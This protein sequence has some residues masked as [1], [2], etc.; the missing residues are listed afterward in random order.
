MAEKGLLTH[1]QSLVSLVTITLFIPCLANFFMI[2]KE[3]GMKI[4]IFMAVIVFP[5]AF[6][7]GGLLNWI[8]TTFNVVL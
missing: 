5:V 1:I 7:S 4:A 3:M 6:L 2:I 8:L